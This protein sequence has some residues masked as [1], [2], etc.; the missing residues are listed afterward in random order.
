MRLFVVG[1]LVVAGVVPLV[2]DPPVTRAGGA[3][4]RQADDAAAKAVSLAGAPRAEE[5]LVLPPLDADMACSTSRSAITPCSGAM[6][7]TTNRSGTF[8]FTIQNKT[9]ENLNYVLTCG[10]T[11][12][13]ASC[14]APGTLA[15][16]HNSSRNVTIGWTSSGTPGSGTLTLTADDDLTPVTGTETFTVS[17]PATTPLYVAQVSPHLQR[18]LVDSGQVDTAR[19]VVRNAGADSTGWSWTVATCSGSAISGSCSPTS[20][21]VNLAAG[22][23]S[24]IAVAYTTTGAKGASGTVKLRFN[25]TADAT[26]VDSGTVELLV[27]RND[28]LVQVSQ[29]NP[30]ESVEPDQ[31][32]TVSVARGLAA[33]CGA[34]RATHTFPSLRTYNKV[35][36]PVLLYNSQNAHPRPVVR[37]DV[38]LPDTRIPDSVTAALKDSAGTAISGAT[39]SWTGSQWRARSTRRV[40][41]SFDGLSWPTGYHRYTLDVR[42]WYAGSPELISVTGTLS[43]VNRSASRY[44]AGWWVAGLERI[45]NPDGIVR[46]T[47]GDGATRRYYSVGGN[48]WVTPALDRP[49]TIVLVGT[50][51]W[52]R[53]LPHGLKV[54]YDYN[55][56]LQISTINRQGHVTRFVYSGGSDQLDSIVAPSGTYPASW[57]FRYNGSGVLREVEVIAYFVSARKDSLTSSSGQIT[58]I[59]QRDGTTVQFTYDGSETNRLVTRTD[60]RGVR[61]SVVFAAGSVVSKAK[62]ARD[63][64]NTTYDSLLLSVAETRGLAGTAAVSLD[65]ASTVIDGFR[66][67]VADTTVYLVNRWGAP[68]RVRNALG[69]ETQL[70][71]ANG[72]FP[73]LVTSL[74]APNGRALVASYDNRGNIATLLDSATFKS[75]PVYATTQYTWDQAWDFVTKVINP[76]GDSTKSAYDATNGNL[77]WREDGRDSVTRTKFF[78]DA[79]SGLLVRS[80]TAMGVWDS[81]VYEPTYLNA[82]KRTNALDQ[83]ELWTQDG[84]GRIYRTERPI[85]AGGAVVVDSMVFD[86]MDRPTLTT[87]R[88]GTDTLIVAQTYTAAGQLQRLTKRSANDASK[89]NVGTL[90]T[91]YLYDGRNRITAESLPNFNT[92]SYSYD[93]ASNLLFG[94]R[95]PATVTYDA[96]NRPAVKMAS[97]TSTFVYDEV[98]NMRHA[99]NAVGRVARTYGKNGTLITDSLRI[100]TRRTSERVFGSNVFGIGARYDLN[101]RRIAFQ[102]PGTVAPIGADSQRLWF[103]GATGFMDSVADVF[104]N[105]F[106]FIYDND[107]RPIKTIRF[108]QS[109]SAMAETLAYDTVGRLR[110]RLQRTANNADTL[111]RDSLIYDLRDR[112][113]QNVITNDYAGYNA[114]GPLDTVTYG[115]G[116]YEAY[117]TDALGLRY[118]GN[119]NAALNGT[120]TYKYLTGSERMDKMIIASQ[121]PTTVSP[122]STLYSWFNGGALGSETRRKWFFTNCSLCT[123]PFNT[124]EVRTTT[125]NIDAS[126]RLISSAF[127]LETLPNPGGLYKTYQRKETYRYDP[128]G[129]RV[130]KEMIRD[131]AQ[132]VC[133]FHDASSGCRNEVTRTVWDGANILYD[134]R[135]LADTTGDGSEG[136]PAASTF[137]GSVGYT[138]AGGIDVP[139]D[140]W[141]GTSVVVPYADWRG[142]YD[143]GTCPTTRCTDNQAY[144][145]LKNSTSFGDGPTLPNGPPNWFG[146]V[147]GGQTDGSGYRYRRNRY[148]DPRVGSFTQ[149]DPIGLSGGL[150][151]YGYANGDPIGFGDPFGLCPYEGSSRSMSI[152]DCEAGKLKDAAA[153]MLADKS[154]AGTRS[155]LRM[156]TANYVVKS[157]NGPP[158]TCGKSSTTACTDP[159]TRT[160]HVNT[161]RSVDAVGVSMTHEGMHAAPDQGGIKAGNAGMD[162]FDQL[163]EAQ[164]KDPKSKAA[165]AIRKADQ[166]EF[167]RQEKERHE[168][169]RKQKPG[170]NP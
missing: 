45:L 93:A 73:A 170:V 136:Y 150:S 146:E 1:A 126:W 83:Y 33:E 39:G 132:S 100:A 27:T 98:G 54:R 88:S 113:K 67:D 5:R 65:R 86:A 89:A 109:A 2:M 95:N 22:A 138:H 47:G 37:A 139:L 119:G 61:D 148:Y 160:I 35:R 72:T 58:S 102:H 118:Y 6:N 104:G 85:I 19:F 169:A 46:W 68:T 135:M 158:P 84:A 96:L 152:A 142:T 21:T 166:A 80:L 79:A 18:H 99:F 125:N 62:V 29:Q 48:A 69:D 97:D 91:A 167:D 140:L 23:Q 13:I 14:S 64:S 4:A 163:D 49:D 63:L 164:K 154:G 149:E 114:L 8:T 56:G 87:T 159:S 3:G 76:E 30:G 74:R 155:L 101:L 31:C 157:S 151:L 75:G 9:I 20:G 7:A 141:K 78:Y 77:L 60:P 59:K 165:S 121:T 105:K 50:S 107:A 36:A 123:P 153:L 71:R 24:T 43:I 52:E 41:V 57:A 112:I 66:T 147:I 130:W 34:L 25:Q 106:R 133:V 90:A 134:V 116:G 55:N 108:S 110:R 122:D 16:N 28:S 51:Y 44:G 144:F 131:T 12:S 70:S 137:T 11:G 81:L 15:V 26:R 32:A 128:L 94:G 40:A 143:V 129:R 82:S 115:S 161:A 120:A 42:R 156:M 127:Q 124:R 10:R 103:N 145:P 53:R 162:F 17:G 38:T 111:H 92:L 117:R 168:A